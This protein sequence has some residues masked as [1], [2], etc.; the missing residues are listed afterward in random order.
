MFDADADSSPNDSYG[1]GSD[2]DG[3]AADDNKDH[4]QVNVTQGIKIQGPIL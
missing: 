4:S 3:H 2:G 1:D